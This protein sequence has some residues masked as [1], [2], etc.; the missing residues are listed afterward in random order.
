MAEDAVRT[1]TVPMLRSGAY[2]NVLTDSE[3][4]FLEE[5]M[6]LEKNA[7]SIHRK[8]NNYWDNFFVSLRKQPNY[9][10]LKDPNDYIKYKVLLANK[11]FIADSLRTLE[12]NRKATYQY[13]IVEEGEETSKANRN[14][15]FTMQAYM[16][17][18]KIQDNYDTLRVLVEILEGKPVS[19][20][21]KIE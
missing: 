7:L 11:D 6:G 1:Y 19:D 5:Y 18:G 13:V 17:F 9:F 2:V 8:D 3:K 12:D 21:T 16:E 14:L 15:S 20:K 10:D 4:E